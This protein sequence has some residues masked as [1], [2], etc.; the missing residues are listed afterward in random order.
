MNLIPIALKKRTNIFIP[1]TIFIIALS[2]RIL[3]LHE[4]KSSPLFHY[5]QVDAETYVSIARQ[6]ANGEFFHTN[7]LSFYQPPLYPILLA[8]IFKTISRD[9]Y[10]IHLLQFIMGSI[11]CVLIYYLGR[12]CFNRKV[13]LLSGLIAC[14]YW[15]FIYFDGELL[16][17]TLIIFLYLCLLL[18]LLKYMESG[19][20]SHA[21]LAGFMLGLSTIARPNILIFGWIVCPLFILPLFV[22]LEGKKNNQI[23][24][25]KFVD[26]AFFLIGSCCIIAPVTL[27]N[28]TTEKSFVLISHNGG[29]NFYIGNSPQNER[30]IDIRPGEEWDAFTAIPKIENPTIQ[31]TG[32]DFSRYWYRK[33]LNYIKY[34]PFD[35][36][37]N[38]LRKSVCFFHAYEFKRNLDIY[39]F[40]NHF[41]RLLRMPLLSFAIICPLALLGMYL[42]RRRSP[43]ILLLLLFILAYGF[44]VVIFFVTSRY[45]LPV[46]P[47]MIIFASFAIL[48]LIK[49]INKREIPWISIL[50]LTIA[51]IFVNV[52]IFKLRPGPNKLLASEAESWY[53]VGRALGNQASAESSY[54]TQ[55]VS[56]NKAIEI[57]QKSAAFDSSFAYPHTFIGIYKI[58]IAKNLMT[59]FETDAHLTKDRI[60]IVNNALRNLDQ[61][62]EHFRLARHINFKLTSP[63]YNLCLALYYRNI[64][65]YN[66]S[67]NQCKVVDKNI[68]R[69]CDEIDNITDILLQSKQF[70]KYEKYYRIKKKARLQKEA[71]IN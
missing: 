6:I 25:M 28:W 39:F 48:Q 42:A 67:D 56:Y 23:I 68:I 36:T 63:L 19:K 37:K 49:N 57:M 60:S 13:G 35:F 41:S 59:A 45:R 54:E 58:Q 38:V 47:I 26:L 17:P 1:L 15:P 21:L 2:V 50:V 18:F 30:V 62:E 69:R 20:K 46:V 52:D 40:K 43:K 5:P 53:F 65:E 27:Y 22:R 66:F 8:F 10:L 3:Y 14:F 34:H 29:L 32:A 16:I 24:K 11:N 71:V 61:A 7:S 70:K 4:I 51:V 44:S 31:L 9:L 64:I 55:M 33:S 12:L